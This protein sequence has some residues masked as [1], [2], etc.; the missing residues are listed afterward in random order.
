MK[1]MNLGIR[2][3]VGLSVF[4]VII[5]AGIFFVYSFVSLNQK[6]PAPIRTIHLM[7]EQVFLP[8]NPEISFKITKADFLPKEECDLTFPQAIKE[9]GATFKDYISIV[10]TLEVNNNTDESWSAHR[11]RESMLAVGKAYSN[12]LDL[13][14]TIELGEE[15]ITP[16]EP[17]SSQEIKLVYSMKDISFA[18]N[19]WRDILLQDYRLVY[20]LYPS[21]EEIELSLD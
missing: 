6:Y 18:P 2:R 16:I 5:V 1:S 20:N 10:L 7:S 13:M 15:N 3:T 11:L 21:I 4:F 8:D 19:T 12:G 17:N 9:S 14:A